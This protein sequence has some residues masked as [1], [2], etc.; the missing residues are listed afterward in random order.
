M[1][2]VRVL[3]PSRLSGAC[4]FKASRLL[5]AEFCCR[6]FSCDLKALSCSGLFWFPNPPS[7][8][9][10]QDGRMA[11]LQV[12][13]LASHQPPTRQTYPVC[14]PGLKIEIMSAGPILQGSRED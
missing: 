9:L 3:H 11:G 1:E 2:V 5:T 4:L 13:D 12:K 10:Y 6:L 14:F 8:A 7:S